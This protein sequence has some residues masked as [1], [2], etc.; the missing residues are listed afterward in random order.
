MGGAVP[1]SE[2]SDQ[3]FRLVASHGPTPEEQSLA[4]DN[5]LVDRLQASRRPSDSRMPRRSATAA[6]PVSDA[7]IALGGEAATALGGDGVL[8]GLLVLGPKRSGM[9]YENEEMAFLGALSSVATLVLHSADI[10]E[11][12]ESLNQELRGQG[13]QDRRA[14]AA[15]PDPPGPA[16]G[17]AAASGRPPARRRARG[18]RGRR[19]RPDG[20]PGVFDAIKG[21]GAGRPRR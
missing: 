13:G 14:A 17:R 4:P 12:L 10:Q 1:A 3:T 9:P 16:P 2:G 11:T 18:H 7:M 20:E 21:S 15:D 19:P 8:A 5:P 6:D